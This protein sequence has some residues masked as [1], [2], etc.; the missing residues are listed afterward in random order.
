MTIYDNKDAPLNT[1]LAAH[2][3]L[4]VKTKVA[5]ESLDAYEKRLGSEELEV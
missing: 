2:E 1:H 4:A 3:T 5:L